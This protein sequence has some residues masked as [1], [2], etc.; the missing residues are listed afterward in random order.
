MLANSAFYYGLLRALS[1][2]DRPVWTKMS[3]AAAEQ[4]FVA[5]AKHGMEAQLYWPGLGRVASDELVL[6]HLLPMAHDGL[7]SWDVAPEV[8]DHFLGVIEG[9]A[10]TGRN[11]STWQVATVHALQD[12]GLT[13]PQALA[14][15]LRRYCERMHSN[16]PVHTW[17]GS[18]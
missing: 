6:R 16:E 11:G 18:S 4:N 12:G 8:R 14:E 3:F 5:A 13:R 10:K 15:M 7:T 17:D 9:R 1:D 2:E